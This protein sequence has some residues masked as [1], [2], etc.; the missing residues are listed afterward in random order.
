MLF[1]SPTVR[2]AG[3]GKILK[4]LTNDNILKKLIDAFAEGNNQ[5]KLASS[6]RNLLIVKAEGFWKKHYVFKE[7]AKEEI[8]YFVGL[9]RADEIIINVILPVAAVY[10]D[11]FSNK[12]AARKV[13]ALFLNY[14]QKSTNQVVQ[15]VAESL[16][17]KKVESK[18]VYYQGMVELFRH[19]CV[20][21]K[22]L[23]C[24]IGKS[25][26]G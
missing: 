24:E 5:A 22:C 20:K 10:F 19:F 17:L 21:E 8:K 14:S 11:I 15:Q 13:K 25:I 23:E 26:F 16:K 18:S 7:K 3:G 2:L 9:S 4:R 12:Q 1:R 6:L